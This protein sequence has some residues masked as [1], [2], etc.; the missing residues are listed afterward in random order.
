MIEQPD[1]SGVSLLASR[2]YGSRPYLSKSPRMLS[3]FQN[4]CTKEAYHFN[5]NADT[6][7]KAFSALVILLFLPT[8]L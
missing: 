7:F 5:A 1:L 8:D 2:L 3:L 4:A 6:K